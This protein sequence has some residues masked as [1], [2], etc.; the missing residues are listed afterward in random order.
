MQQWATFARSWFLIDARMQP[1]GKLA[2][3][4]SVRL[5][6]KHKPIY[7]AMSEWPS[8]IGSVTEVHWSP[9]ARPVISVAKSVCVYKPT[10]AHLKFLFSVFLYVKH[11]CICAYSTWKRTVKQILRQTEQKLSN[12]MVIV[13]EMCSR[14]VFL[15]IHPFFKWNNF[16]CLCFAGD[17]GDH[18][19][20]INARHIA[21]SGNKWEQKVYSSH[22]G[23]AWV[24]AW[25]PQFFFPHNSELCKDSLVV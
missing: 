19:V 4:C 14:C 20:I 8:A 9:D 25:Y 16:L 24:L 10:K 15:P 23:W 6:G 18:V 5:Q 13:L 17:C 2:T 3:M 12:I 22:T 11:S 1:P 7:H 21:F